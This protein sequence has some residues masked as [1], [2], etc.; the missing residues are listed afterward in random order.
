MTDISGRLRSASMTGAAFMKFGRAP[1][2]QITFMSV[3]SMFLTSIL[4]GLPPEIG[5]ARHVSNGPDE[6]RIIEKAEGKGGG[7]PAF[8]YSQSRQSPPCERQPIA[9]RLRHEQVGEPSFHQRQVAEQQ[10]DEGEGSHEPAQLVGDVLKEQS[11]PPG[12]DEVWTQS[13]SLI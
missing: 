1:T 13:H 3:L 9:H 2:T 11:V 12:R 6:S 5:I 4:Q 10:R 8:S 7:G